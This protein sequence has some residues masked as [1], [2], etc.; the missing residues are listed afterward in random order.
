MRN[1]LIADML[2]DSLDKHRLRLVFQPQFSLDGNQ[3]LTGT[4][5]LIRW[6]HPE[7]GDVSP[8]EFIP[9]AEMTDLILDIDHFVC[10]QLVTLI[11]KW[12]ALALDFPPISVN[13][14]PRSLLE[15]GFAEAFIQ[16][17]DNA[18]I[19]HSLLHVEITERTLLNIDFIVI[20]NLQVL[21]RE[22]I[23]VSIDDF[24]IAY[25]S[26]AYLKHHFACEIKIDRSFV[27]GIGQTIEDEAIIHSMIL[28]GKNLNLRIVAE[29]IET[30]SQLDWLQTAGCPVGQGFLLSRPLEHHDYAALLSKSL[31]HIG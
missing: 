29:G 24:G 6:R 9:V 25:S 14:S 17:I 20:N 26:F 22:K 3:R 23:D 7:L 10:I 21:Q 11:Q 31:V 1:N 30:Q 18:G 4:E 27:S 16:E 19:P 12:R 13:L 2:R 8:A 5:A 15:L 28:L